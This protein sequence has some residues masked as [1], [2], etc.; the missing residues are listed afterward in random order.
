MRKERKKLLPRLWGIMRCMDASAGINRFI[1]YTWHFYYSY[2]K[3]TIHRMEN[4]F[5]RP[6]EEIFYDYMRLYLM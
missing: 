6:T 4:K 5:Y 2:V 1:S 3:I